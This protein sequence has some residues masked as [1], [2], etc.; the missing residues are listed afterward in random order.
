MSHILL[1]EPNTLLAAAYHQAL[2]HAGYEVTHVTG[3]QAAILA[4]DEQAP[5]LVIAELQLPQHSGLEFLHEFRSYADWR[6]VPVIVHTVL[7]PPQLATA[8]EALQRDLGVNLLL[9]KPQT[10]LRDLLDAVRLHIMP[11]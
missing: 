3:A 8:K 5:A 1:L 2:R 11:V 6:Q 10:S 7:S 4:A 9:Y